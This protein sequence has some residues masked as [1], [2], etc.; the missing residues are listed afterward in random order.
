MREKEKAW[1]RVEGEGEG[2]VER[3]RGEGGGEREGRRERTNK[4]KAT[5]SYI[6]SSWK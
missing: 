2:G 3:E 4:T 5:V 1:G 6:T